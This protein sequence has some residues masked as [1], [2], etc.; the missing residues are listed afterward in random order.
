MAKT[1]MAARK[2]CQIAQNSN[3]DSLVCMPSP[4]RATGFAHLSRSNGDG[5]TRSATLSPSRSRPERPFG[6]QSRDLYV[7]M[8][9]RRARHRR[10]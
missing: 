3:G 7:S 9:R 10:G 2:S 6:A 8:V 4:S 5:F 1:V